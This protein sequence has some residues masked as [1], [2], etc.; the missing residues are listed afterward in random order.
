MDWTQLR[1]D[2]LGPYRADAL[3]K[4][5]KVPVFPAAAAR[6]LRASEEPDIELDDLANIIEGDAG[7]A[8]ALLRYVN[9]GVNGRR[10]KANNARKAVGLL[11]LQRSR[12]I[13]IGV[14]TEQS[15]EAPS[16]PGFD[17]S[18]FLRRNLQR[19]LLAQYVAQAL[20]QD[21][22]LAFTGALLA[23]A[24]LPMFA[25]EHPKLYRSVS[26]AEGLKESL[27]RY[28]QGMFGHDHTHT[29]ARV[30]QGWGFPDDVVCCVALH[31]ESMPR[32]KELGAAASAAAAVRLSA[33][34]PDW[35]KQEPNGV[36]KLTTFLGRVPN[37]DL[38]A[39]SDELD[40]VVAGLE[41]GWDRED[42]IRSALLPS[43]EP[44]AT[45]APQ[46]TCTA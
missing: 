30:F 18:T 24:T 25:A 8:S 41:H 19:A 14:A 15:F 5:L 4:W 32:L 21:S 28:E 1:Q 36:E 35:F 11:G 16:L 44:T 23:D 43:A 2:L 27:S 13:V 29:A 38:E 9:G 45:P 22:D 6:F 37:L 17:G 3:P 46:P 20:G 42:S 12:M 10:Y 40:D 31:H 7:L 39:L 33:Y 26:A 34:L